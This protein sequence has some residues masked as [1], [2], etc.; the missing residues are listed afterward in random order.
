MIVWPDNAD[1]AKWYYLD[2]QEAANG[3]DY[4]RGTDGSEYWTEL[5][6]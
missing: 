1:T 2:V 6:N 5:K 3:H 4:A